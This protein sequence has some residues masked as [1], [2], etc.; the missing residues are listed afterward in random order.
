MMI[1]KPVVQEPPQLLVSVGTLDA[2]PE[3]SL[4]SIKLVGVAGSLMKRSP[5]DG[6]ATFLHLLEVSSHLVDVVNELLVVG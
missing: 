6:D 5:N 1:D 4:A 2:P 3:P